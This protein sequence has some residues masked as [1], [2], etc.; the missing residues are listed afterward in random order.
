MV[1]VVVR[2]GAHHSAVF[3]CRIL[4]A[5]QQATLSGSS[6]TLMA[7]C[8]ALSHFFCQSYL[9]DLGFLLI[10]RDADGPAGPAGLLLCIDSSL[11]YC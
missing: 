5:G 3:R 7:T 2:A 8:L 9:N 4:F 1:R 11:L 10:H 6:G